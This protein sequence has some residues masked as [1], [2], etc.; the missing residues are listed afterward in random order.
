MNLAIAGLSEVHRQ[1]NECCVDLEEHLVSLGVL[2]K[3]E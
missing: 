2:G 3:E 1:L